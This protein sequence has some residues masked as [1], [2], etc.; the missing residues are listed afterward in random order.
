MAARGKKGGRII[1][2]VALILILIFG[3]GYVYLT[4]IQGNQ[5]TPT[6][7]DEA[8]AQN[9]VGILVTTQFIAR[10]AEITADSVMTVDYPADKLVQGTFI[11]DLDSIVGDRAKYD[12][13]P[14]VPLTSS[15]LIEPSGGSVTSFD[16][17]QDYVALPIPV[18]DLTSVANSLAPGDHVMVISCMMMVDVD[19]N[20]Q[21]KLPNEVEQVTINTEARDGRIG[22]SSDVL[23]ANEGSVQGRT[24]VD[25]G[26]NTPLY[27]APAEAQRPRT[28]CQTFIQDAV[29]LRLS[30]TTTIAAAQTETDQTEAA[31]AASTETD[32]VTLVVSPQ[33]A[34][35]LNYML[36]YS[37]TNSVTLS[38]ALRNPTDTDP[39]VTDAV[40]QQYLMDQKNIPLPAKLPYALEPRTDS[41]V[42]PLPTA[43]PVPQQ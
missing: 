10:G 36:V 15:V 2:L 32:M 29:V 16:V 30:E 17:P 19:S 6:T 25:A 39:I 24:E 35:S 18:N 7:E 31:T 8:K 14:G 42:F 1:I 21:S 3:G 11:T 40:T 26:L 20:Y 37:T 43:T 4:M 27:I 12:L 23:P 41:L 38:L 9:M 5:G 13:D 33:D 22:V 28:V 34:I